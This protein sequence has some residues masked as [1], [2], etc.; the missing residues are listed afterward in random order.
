MKTIAIIGAARAQSGIRSS[1]MKA[2]EA[3]TEKCEK[4]TKSLTEKIERNSHALGCDKNADL[5]RHKQPK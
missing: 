5:L 2:V 4:I 3:A 1:I